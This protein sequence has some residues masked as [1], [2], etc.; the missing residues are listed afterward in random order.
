MKTSN[1]MRLSNYTNAKNVT[2]TFENV[3][4][5]YENMPYA[6]GDLMWAGLI[7]YQPAGADTNV[8][9]GD[10]YSD[11]ATKTWTFNFINCRY[12]GEKVTGNSFGTNKQVIYQYNVK[13]EGKSED[14]TVFGA[15]NFE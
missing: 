3:D 8:K 4:W 10:E 9:T 15:I 13:N 7:I 2:V 1:I 14:P 5:T 11:E 12:N 6:D